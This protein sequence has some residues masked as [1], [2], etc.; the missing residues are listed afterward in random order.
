MENRYFRDFRAIAIGRDDVAFMG[1]ERDVAVGREMAA[2][3]VLL[4]RLWILP[5]RKPRARTQAIAMSEMMSAYSTSVCPLSFLT[6]KR[7]RM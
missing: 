5:L 1:F 6:L 3:A 7:A 2:A 4:N